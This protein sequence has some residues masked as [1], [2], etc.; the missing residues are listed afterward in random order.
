M[1]SFQKDFQMLCQEK[2]TRRALLDV[3]TARVWTYGAL[4][5]HVIGF[6]TFLKHQG[7]KPGERIFSILPNSVE[8]L[9]AF[10][11]SLWS[12]IDFCPISPLSTTKEVSCFV[13]MAGCV[14]GLVPDGVDDI[15]AKQWSSVV[16]RGK[17][18]PIHL[19]GDLSRYEADF[20][21]QRPRGEVGRLII[22]TSG[23]TASP[24][25]L[26]LNGDRLWS[27]AKAW[28][29]FHS[30]LIE[31]SRFYNVF[32]MS[33]LGGLFNLG[34][35]PLS[36][37]GSVV[38]THAFSGVSAL[39]FFKEVEQYGVNVLWFAPTILRVLQHLYKKQEVWRRACQKMKVG[40]LGMAP[41]ALTEKEAFEEKLGIQLLENYALSET[42][43]ITSETLDSVSKRTSGSVGEIL[44]WAKI[45]FKKSEEKILPSEIEVQTPFLFE[46][47]LE[48]KE[49]KKPLLSPDGF[50]PTGDLGILGEE[51]QLRIKG[52]IKEVVKKGGY[53]VLLRDL[54]EIA[55]QHPAVL[56]A[57]AFKTEHPF[58]GETPILCLQVEEG[59]ATKA[60]LE[61]VKNALIK[62]AA[63]FRWPSEI[64][65]M[66]SF[67]RTESGKTK[68]QSLQDWYSQ[69]KNILDSIAL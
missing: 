2:G 19:D 34:L 51:G 66:T 41:I 40:F 42:T 24:K 27:A 31:E 8:Q 37:S 12:G 15:L 23:T 5:E 28:S 17:L 18:L 20:N 53:L 45:Q 21:S 6:S 39:S 65:A 62:N 36:C 10:L 3:K 7:V 49:M 50:F 33:Y 25:A 54:E 56:E 30:F 69:K 44:P 9:I 35:I 48:S 11:A 58:Y 60:I 47:Y 1:Q 29:Q 14:S 61:G 16:S 63:K 43:F 67:P 26:V 52:R 57:I 22:F 59:K 32:P 38:L 68:R 4:W 64:V 46:S 55:A 13:E